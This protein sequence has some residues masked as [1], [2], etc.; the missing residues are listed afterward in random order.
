MLSVFELVSCKPGVSREL[1]LRPQRSVLDNFFFNDPLVEPKKIPS[2]KKFHLSGRWS[3]TQN[4][5]FQVISE[6]LAWSCG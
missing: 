2:S 6:Y 4:G 3:K 1:A 5:A